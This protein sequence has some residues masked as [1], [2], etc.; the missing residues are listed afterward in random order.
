MP[1]WSWRISYRGFALTHFRP[2]ATCFFKPR[3]LATVAAGRRQT[4]LGTGTTTPVPDEAHPPRSSSPFYFE[5]GYALYAKRPS[6]PFPPP[7]LSLPSTSFSDP[8][9]THHRSRDRWSY[10]NGE[11]IRGI[12]NGDDAVLVSENFIGANDGVGAWSTKER[13]HAALWSRLILHFWALEAERDNYGDPHEPNPVEYLHKAFEHTKEATSAPTEWLGTTTAS[14]AILGSDAGNAPHPIL[15]VT[16]LGDSQILVLRPQSKEVIFKTTEQWHW[17]DCPRQLGTN[18]PDTPKENAVMDRIKIQEDDV[19]LAMSDGVIDNLWEHEVLQN[20]VDSITKWENGEALKDDKRD[21]EEKSYADGML[22][23]AQE[24]VKAARTIAEDPFAESP[25]ME[26][27][28]DEGL[29]IEG[30]KLDDISVVAAQCKR[31]K[32]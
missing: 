8:L 1:T 2:S 12:T 29:S 18:S 16:Q 9:S 14:G 3:F 30:G 15:Y 22:Y 25:Y 32:G 31:R 23:V 10:V 5:A 17:F 6:R 26:K 11:M 27:A 21:M 19:V 20:V 28:I 13:G 7:F 24:L 4:P